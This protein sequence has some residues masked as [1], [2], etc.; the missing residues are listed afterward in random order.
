MALVNRTG[1]PRT[2]ANM[3]EGLPARETVYEQTPS[4][5]EELRVLDEKLKDIEQIRGRLNLESFDLGKCRAFLLA[6]I[7][8]QSPQP[9]STKQLAIWAD[10]FQT[11]EH[12]WDQ[13]RRIT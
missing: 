3:T 10:E 7:A 12:Q 2:L 5:L 6:R 9:E 1:A 4:Q 8:K 11:P 13:S